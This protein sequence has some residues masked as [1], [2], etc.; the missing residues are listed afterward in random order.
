MFTFI[1]PANGPSR[2]RRRR[3]RYLIRV[4]QATTT[5]CLPSSPI[6]NIG[7]VFSSKRVVND[8]DDGVIYRITW[9]RSFLFDSWKKKK[10]EMFERWQISTRE[11]YLREKVIWFHVNRP[12]YVHPSLLLFSF[13]PGTRNR[14]SLLYLSFSLNNA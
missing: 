9:S 11:R 5:D 13:E 10:E 2:R 12:P 7:R 1:S 6:R 14:P 8:N 3:E 4:F